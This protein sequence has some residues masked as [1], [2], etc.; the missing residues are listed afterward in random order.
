MRVVLFPHAA[1]SVILTAIQIDIS[2]K[3]S[4]SGTQLVPQCVV[5]ECLCDVVDWH[6]EFDMWMTIAPAQSH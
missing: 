1:L 6:V 2:A 4:W 3:F 5:L